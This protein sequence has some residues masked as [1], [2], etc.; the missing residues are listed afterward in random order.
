MTSESLYA[1]KIARYWRIR[2]IADLYRQL[3]QSLGLKR[4]RNFFGHQNYGAYAIVGRPFKVMPKTADLADVLKGLSA[5][6]DADKATDMY[7]E[8][9]QILQKAAKR[10]SFLRLN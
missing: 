7:V 4:F 5:D 9:L 10:K 2:S 3:I 8:R 1:F 6:D